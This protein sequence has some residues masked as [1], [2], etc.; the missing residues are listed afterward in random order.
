MEHEMNEEL[1]K[2]DLFKILRKFLPYLR[3][4]WMLL[5]VLAVVNGSQTFVRLYRAY[6]PM[7]K[8]EAMFAVQINYDGTSDISSYRHNYDKTAAEQ[9]VDTF[10]YILN[11]SIMRELILQELD[12][13]YINGSTSVQAIPG[14]NFFLMT[15]TS[16]NPDDAYQVL[17]ATIARYPQVSQHILGST[18]I[19]LIRD[20]VPPTA[21][22]NH[23]TWQKQVAADAMS[24]VALG[25]AILVA[26]AFLRRTVMSTDDV[27]RIISLPCLASVPNIK[28]KQRKSAAQTSLLISNQQSDSAFCEAFR[29][30]RL[31]L[32]RRLGE[33]DRILM[34]TS[35]LPSEGKSSLAA[36]TALSLAKD[37]KKVLLIDADLR[38]PSVKG[39]LGV[40]TPSSGLGDYL[41]EGLDAVNFLRYKNTRLYLFAGDE[42]ISDPTSLLQLEK[43]NTLIQSLRPMFDYVILDTPPCSMMADAAAFAQHADKVV[44]VIREDYASPNQIYDGVQSIGSTGADICG[45]VYNRASSVR[46]S[47]YGYGYGRYGYGKRYGYGY[48]NKR[49]AEQE[50]T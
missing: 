22:Y 8:C 17:M 16:S 35:T 3:K 38:S 10:P 32:L 5:L 4:F 34:F 30:L 1:E 12:T 36:N 18:Q 40:D 24:G 27:K 13:P 48:G 20:P 28:A 26:M 39:L 11:S 15:V 33:D 2:I 37:G 25:L 46:T 31:K 6:R 44:Y 9:V 42:V 43:M 23:F 41:Q 45:Y 49:S 50:T 19:N 7:Y 21:P 29:L 47:R 14:T